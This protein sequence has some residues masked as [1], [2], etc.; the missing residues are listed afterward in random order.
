MSPPPEPDLAWTA[1]LYVAGDLTPD[2]AARFE[3]QLDDDQGAREAVAAAVELAGAVARVAA[4]FPS[5]R[6]L[7]SRRALRV[8]G[9]L[10]VAAGLLLA[11]GAWL[12][13]ADPARVAD[14]SAVAL[15][16][17][18][19]RELDGPAEPASNALVELPFDRPS[20]PEAE[21]DAE[22]STDRPLPSWLLTATSAG[23]VDSPRR[24]D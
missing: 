14:E 23:A 9:G 2:E 7:V 6:R 15:A 21:G 8:A 4:E 18:N 22:P 11:I 17:S 19:L 10:A 24:E 13:V 3:A 1:F 16:W 20:G 5:P 12:R